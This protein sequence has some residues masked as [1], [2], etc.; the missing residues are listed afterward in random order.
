M[1]NITISDKVFDEDISYLYPYTEFHN[2]SVCFKNTHGEHYKLISHIAKQF[3][4]DST[5]VDIG[6]FMGYSALALSTNK[7]ARVLTYDLYDVTEFFPKDENVLT[8]RNIPNI[9]AIVKNC[10]E[11]IPILLEAPL[12]VLDVDPHDGIQEKEIITKLHENGY[13]GIVLCDDIHLNSGMKDFWNWV[14]LKKIDVSEYGHHSGS[15]IIVFDSKWCDIN[16]E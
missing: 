10:L 3:P 2:H 11:D 1:M 7:Y 9:T 8:M 4:N 15:G 12:I 16:V 13:K 14:S 6:T 5:F